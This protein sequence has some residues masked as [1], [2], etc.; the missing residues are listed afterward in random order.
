M[1]G[2]QALAQVAGQAFGGAQGALQAQLDAVGGD[3]GRGVHA[4]PAALGQ[5]DFGPGVGVGLAHHVVIADLV[6]LAALIAGDHARRDVCGAHHHRKGRG[7]V[8][9][10]TAQGLEQEFVHRLRPQAGGL[11]RVD[12][13]L[14]AKTPQRAVDHLHIVQ[15]F[16][17]P[18]VH[19]FAGAWAAVVRQLGIDAAQAIVQFRLQ[20]VIRVGGQFVEPPVVDAPARQQAEIAGQGTVDGQCGGRRDVQRHH[21]A[22]A[23]GFHGD[24]VAH[25]AAASQRLWWLPV[26][27]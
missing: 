25:P 10:E 8:F 23:V 16:G 14:L 19:Q 15:A 5:P 11:Q 6:F 12:I 21:P 4:Q 17:A 7:V 9:A 22:P 13:L 27:R 1:L 20:H 18:L 24:R 2:A 3:G 26:A